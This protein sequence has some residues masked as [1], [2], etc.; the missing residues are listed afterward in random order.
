M[1]GS[2]VA[3]HTRKLV[4]NSDDLLKVEK[5]FSIVIIQDGRRLAE[6]EVR[7]RSIST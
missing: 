3:R 5:I 7:P 2:C 6:T 4:Y 1:K